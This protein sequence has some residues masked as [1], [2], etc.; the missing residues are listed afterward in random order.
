MAVSTLG[1]VN[2]L[3]DVRFGSSAF[4]SAAVNLPTL[5]ISDFCLVFAYFFSSSSG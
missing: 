5:F 1:F 4:S 2:D 3:C